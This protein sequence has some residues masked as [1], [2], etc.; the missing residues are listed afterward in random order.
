MGLYRK[1]TGFPVREVERLRSWIGVKGP[2]QDNRRKHFGSGAG[3]G[4]TKQ[5]QLRK[6]PRREV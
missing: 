2:L 5:P 6:F 3:S 1:R 4:P